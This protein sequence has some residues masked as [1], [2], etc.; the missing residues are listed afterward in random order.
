MKTTRTFLVL[1][2]AL[3]SSL[4]LATACGRETADDAKTTAA[5]AK[6]VA[7]AVEPEV[8]TTASDTWAAIKDSTYDQR[9]DFTAGVTHMLER[10]DVGV[11]RLTVK[12]ATL[13][14]T[15]VKDWDFAMKELNEAASDLHSKVNDLGK[16]M[17]ET[18]SETK[19]R[20]AQAWQRARDAYD[21]VRTSTTA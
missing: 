15:S 11:G 20:I 10:L 2:S 4:F 5:D 18:W 14:Q 3:G 6:T 17:P 9:A 12:R 8:M 13:P 19:D 16:A 21:K 7:M 1:L